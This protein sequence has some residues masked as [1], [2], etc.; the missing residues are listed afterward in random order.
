MQRIADE[1]GR[2]LGAAPATDEA[3]FGREMDRLL[4]GST[5]AAAE[6]L[7]RAMAAS[8]RHLATVEAYCR[9]RL[10]E[11]AAKVRLADP[12]GEAALDEAAKAA[13]RQCQSASSAGAF[14]LLGNVWS[15]RAEV[16]KQPDQMNRAVEAWTTAAAMDPYGL[17]FPMRVFRTELS[18]GHAETAR[19]WAGRLLDLDKLQRLDELKRLTPSERA[20]I[21]GAL[22]LP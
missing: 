12:N 5:A 21:E 3:S 16:L 7:A 8:P 17:T 4:A 19:R 6:E 15:T 2:V 18:L 1:L 9:M 22:R 20:E 13:Q 10:S 11:G 14:G